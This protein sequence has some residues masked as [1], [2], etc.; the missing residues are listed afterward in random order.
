MS[1]VKYF[2]KKLSQM[3]IAM[4]T[5]S[6]LLP[7]TAF[8]SEAGPRVQKE[9]DAANK[10][11][12]ETMT[13]FSQARDELDDLNA[14]IAQLED[15]IYITREEITETEA[16]IADYDVQLAELAAAIATLEEEITDQ[17][18]DLNKKLRIMYRTDQGT[19]MDVLLG[20]VDVIDFLSNL[21]MVQRI[22]SSDRA[23]LDEL[24]NKLDALESKNDS[25]LKVK[26]D[27]DAQ[28]SA[29]VGK[30]ANLEVDKIILD[31]SR[32][33]VQEIKDACYEDLIA[34]EKESKRIERELATLSS[35]IDYN[36]GLFLWP[37]RGVITSE[38]GMRVNPV[39]GEF[40]LHAGIDIGV[41]EGTPIVAAQEGVVISAEWKGSYG[42]MLMIDHGVM[43][44][45]STLVTCY[46]HNSG[47]A[48]SAGSIVRKG[49]VVAYAGS[50]GNSTG[51]HCHFEVRVNGVPQ[52]P[53]DW[54]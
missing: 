25:I 13:E 18:S 26:G 41:P 36:G 44:D 42:N 2:M 37:C 10:N 20:S 17:N 32:K 48:V 23:L 45:G 50:T 38:Y 52:N 5:V 24:R 46:A 40:I 8:A 43:D 29:L 27:L 39:S 31:I 4:L 9:L 49:D 54:L 1:E 7:S 19:M 34:A 28:E 6:L 33:R 51:S 12:V 22:H 11:V 30:K 14:Q 15:Q 47:F 53:R 16:L 21:G 35:D 3:V